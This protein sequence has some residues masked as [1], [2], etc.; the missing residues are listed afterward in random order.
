MLGACALAF[1]AAAHAADQPPADVLAADDQIIAKGR[2]SYYSLKA[3]GMSGFSCQLV[4]DFDKALEDLRKTNASEA[5]RRAKLFPRMH[6]ELVAP[7]MG[8]A[9]VTHSFDGEEPA[10]LAGNFEKIYNGMDQ[11][12][13]GFFMTWRG[14]MVV[15]VFPKPGQPYT[16]EKVQSGY[17]IYYPDGGAD[18][19]IMTDPDLVISSLK[20]TTP[21]FVA[22]IR[23]QFKKVDGKL[24]LAA[25]E[26][27]YQG[28]EPGAKT[29]AEARVRIDY[30]KVDG[31]QLPQYLHIDGALNGKPYE[32][33]I[34]FTGCHITKGNEPL[35]AQA[36][37]AAREIM[38]K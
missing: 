6:F 3:E 29:E 9:V 18:A 37:P 32:V 33:G 4:P 38:K 30:Q 21:K 15:D 8:N 26:A 17:R 24:V 7:L 12:A 31:F 36:A 13:R 11:M 10:D 23:P 35:P 28:T 2:A 14:F 22:T 5:E 34:A 25:Y 20:I 27:L 1:A 16:L 19:L